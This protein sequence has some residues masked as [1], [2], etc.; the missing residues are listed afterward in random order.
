M[1]NPGWIVKISLHETELEKK[2]FE[3]VCIDRSE[4]DWLH[5]HTR[6]LYFEGAGGPFN[7]PEILKVFRE[8]AEY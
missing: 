7:L 6:N 1:D 8:W 5:C 4:D 2:E 3:E